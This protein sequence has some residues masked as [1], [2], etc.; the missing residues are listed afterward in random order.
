MLTLFAAGIAALAII[1]SFEARLGLLDELCRIAYPT[2]I[3]VFIV[4]ALML[5]RWPQTITIARWTCF[6]ALNV[7]LLL[8]FVTAI[9]GEGP[10]VGNYAFISMLMWLPLAY[11]IALLMLDI[12]HAP[13][14]AGALLA[15]IAATSIEQL[16]GA[17]R[18]AAGDL[19]LLINLVASHLV[20]LACLSGLLKFKAALVQA[21]ADSRTLLR[22]AS[23]DPLTGLANRRHGLKM[24]QQAALA[25]RSDECSAIVLCDIDHFKQINDHHGHDAGDQV[26][27]RIASVL[28]DNTRDI[29][30][31]VRWGGDE[32]LV[33]VPRIGM[34]ALAELAERLRVRTRTARVDL[35]EV[36]ITPQISLGVATRHDGEAIEPWL[37]RA[38]LALYQA[39]TDGRNRCVFAPATAPAAFSMP[40][41]TPPQ[42]AARVLLEAD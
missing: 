8:Q 6:A 12:R 28:R 18:F 5:Y 19:A 23:T 35:G 20:L 2:M 7:L 1:W 24:L 16:V 27:L 25:Q 15:A 41:A 40:A 32:Y 13:W 11:A 17:S 33:V 9:R 29:D 34:Q 22:Q 3:G 21:D 37:K 31:V 36:S 4:S 39:K 26:V 14:A 30:T 38:D 42:A 10:L